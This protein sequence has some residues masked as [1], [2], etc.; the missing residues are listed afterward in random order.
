MNSQD[1]ESNKLCTRD[2][3]ELTVAEFLADVELLKAN[4]V[5]KMMTIGL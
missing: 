5:P 2:G 4:K 3:R 1:E